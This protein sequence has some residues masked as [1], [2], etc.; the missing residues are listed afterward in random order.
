MAI[1]YNT[2]S[3]L[4]G[5]PSYPSPAYC[6]MVIDESGISLMRWWSKVAMISMENVHSMRIIPYAV[7]NPPQMVNKSV[8][9]RAVLGGVLLGP[10]DPSAL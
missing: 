2:V 3:Y 1:T 10:S 9:T 6:R 8:I 7:Y 5:L 4:G